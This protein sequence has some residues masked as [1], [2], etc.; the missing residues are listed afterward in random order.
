MVLDIDADVVQEISASIDAA[1]CGDSTEESVLAELVPRQF[2]CAVV[3]IGA[4]SVEASILTT[5]L[6]QKLQIPR[7]V[8]RATSD[9]HARVLDAIGAHEVLNPE[10]EMGIA[11]GRRLSVPNLLEH[12][13]LGDDTALAE[14]ALPPGWEGKAI[15]ET[16][17]RRH[18][19]TLVAIRR[20]GRI[21]RLASDRDVLASADLLVVL[22]SNEEIERLANLES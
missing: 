5:A 15:S 19:V 6:L 17:M 14:V 12:L 16:D 21:L 7:I 22:G 3:T 9:L 10:A 8:A 11:L 18:G 4:S 20:G 1:V 2:D 13:D